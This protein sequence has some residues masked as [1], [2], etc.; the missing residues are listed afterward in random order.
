MLG[1]QRPGPAG[2]IVCFANVADQPHTI[3][4][5]TLSGLPGTMIDL[6][7]DARHTLRAGLTLPAH[8]VVWLHADHELA[9]SPAPAG[10][11]VLPDGTPRAH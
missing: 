3:A 5:L 4:A 7:T 10:T 9:S 11:A 6:L 8:G 1:Y 2:A